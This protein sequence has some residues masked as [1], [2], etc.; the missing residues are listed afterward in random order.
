LWAPCAGPILGIILTGAALNGANVE[1]SL[2]L[3]TFAA[4]AATS[5]A[6]AL[7]LGGQVFAAM[8][9]S[10]RVSEWVRRGVGVAVI[11]AVAAISLGLDTGVLTRISTES[12][13]RR[14][15]IARPVRA[16]LD[17]NKCAGA[18]PVAV[19]GGPA[20]MSGNPAMMGGG[21]AMSGN[22][23]MMDGSP[24]M[25]ILG[26]LGQSPNCR[27]RAL[28]RR[29]RAAEWLNSS[30]LSPDVLKGKVVLIDFWTY[31]C[32]NCLRAIPYVGPGPKI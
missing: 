18:P 28:Y 1:T 4:G 31:S 6:L 19:S 2:L 20:M 12:T 3:L 5:L 22:S 9:R 21:P 15:A 10:L 13:A 24:S 14:T 16:D 27:W 17:H 26:S 7:L 25:V 29:L 30:A 11:V 8:K 32:I 23:A